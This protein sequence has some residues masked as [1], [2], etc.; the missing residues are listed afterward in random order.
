MISLAGIVVIVIPVMLM[1][2]VTLSLGVDFLTLGEVIAAVWVFGHSGSLRIALDEATTLSLGL[3]PDAMYFDLSLAP[4]LLGIFTSILAW[5]VGR[6]FSHDFSIGIAAVT[7]GCVGF[8]IAS[9]LL[10][11]FAGDFVPNPLWLSTLGASLWFIIPVWIGF[12]SQHSDM[13]STGWF[14]LKVGFEQSGAPK[15]G[16]GFETY[17]SRTLRL[18]GALSA[19]VVALGALAVTAALVA[20]FVDVISLTQSLHLDTV[21]V[22]IF[23]LGQLVYLPTLIIWAVS[24]LGGP[25]FVM[26]LGST[27]TPFETLLAPMPGIPVFAALPEGWGSWGFLAILGVVLTGFIVGVVFGN[28]PEYLNPALWR[29]SVVV[30]VAV[31]ITGLLCAL[32]LSLASGSMGPGRLETVGP[33]TWVTAGWITAELGVGVLAGVAV[34]RTRQDH[35][36]V[37]SSKPEASEFVELTV[38]SELT[39]VGAA[40]EEDQVED[41]DLPTPVFAAHHVSH[42]PGDPPS[43]ILTDADEQHTQEIAGLPSTSRIADPIDEDTEPWFRKAARPRKRQPRP[44]FTEE[45]LLEEFSW[46]SKPEEDDQTR[47]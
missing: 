14:R 2:I 11:L 36:A 40:P 12:L 46:E 18:V 21:G 22:L 25:G 8:V 15:L 43:S 31:I 5:R 45:E 13:V 34:R 42:E 23:F 26:G 24:W 27:V 47:E 7:G 39:P 17:V 1:G 37:A 38:S 19:G 29:T 16:W 44:S 4:L 35:L 41:A 28:L 9:L 3:A 10:V 30:L 20:G 33:D 6:R 32:A